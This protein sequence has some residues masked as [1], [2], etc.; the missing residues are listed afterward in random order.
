VRDPRDARSSC[1]S[2]TATAP[3][4]PASVF[5][6]WNSAVSRAGLP[7]LVFIAAPDF[8]WVSTDIDQGADA[9]ALASFK[10]RLRVRHQVADLASVGAFRERL[11]TELTQLQHAPQPPVSQAAAAQAVAVRGT[12]AMSMTRQF[13][14]RRSRV[15]PTA[16]ECLAVP[17]YVAGAPF[18]DRASELAALDELSTAAWPRRSLPPVNQARQSCFRLSLTAFGD[19]APPSGGSLSLFSA[20]LYLAGYTLGPGQVHIRPTEAPPGLPGW[21]AW[22]GLCRPAG[23]TSG[24]VRDALAWCGP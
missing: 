16:P 12:A 8:P 22:P 24:L 4:C 17:P 18:A 19:E 15:K 13:P 14:V 3:G 1:W 6:T 11:F 10:A 7:V 2:G 23:R 21:S 9:S 20:I 5:R